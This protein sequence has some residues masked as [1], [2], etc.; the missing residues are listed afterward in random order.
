MNNTVI[1]ITLGNSV[2]ADFSSMGS[3]A[4]PKVFTVGLNCDTGTHVKMTLDGSSAGPAGVLAFNAG[5]DEASGI[6]SRLLKGG[7][8]VILG[9]VLGLGIAITA[10]SLQ[11][12]L[13]A[14]YYQKAE[15]IVG[16]KTNTKA[17]FTMAY[18]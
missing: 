4:K 7:T 1:N 12:L 3:V 9:S 14:R 13:T 10:G 5:A 11:L 6:R 2:E 16:G 17:A 18:N 8:P 15:P